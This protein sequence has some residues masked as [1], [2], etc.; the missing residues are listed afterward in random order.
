[1]TE[2]TTLLFATIRAQPDQILAF[3]RYHLNSGF[4]HVVVFLDDPAND[5]AGQ[6]AGEPR[7]TCY[8]CD[9]HYWQEQ[10][11]RTA[12]DDLSINDRQRINSQVALNLARKAGYEWIAHVDGDELIYV[13]AGLKQGLKRLPKQVQV[14][15]FPVLEVVPEMESPHHA[16]QDMTLFKQALKT[17]PPGILFSSSWEESLRLLAS[18]AFYKIKQ[19]VAYLAGSSKVKKGYIK[20]HRVGKSIARTAAAFD[21]YLE[22]FPQPKSA[23]RLRVIFFPGGSVLHFDT[24]S[25][26]AWKAK[27]LGRYLKTK[28]EQTPD[29][30][31]PFRARQMAAFVDMYEKGKGQEMAEYFRQEFL[32]SARE[33]RILRKTGLLLEIHLGVEL[34]NDPT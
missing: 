14:A 31:N 7:V 21:Q 22:H 28:Q 24:P 16:F 3:V 32:L 25:F 9:E 33:R 5:A 2:L 6:L 30:I 23:H 17:H 12:P 8:R 34:F 10:I 4:D 1:M 27:W 15:R 29:R 20:G 13:P 19:T 26:A 18:R 11:G